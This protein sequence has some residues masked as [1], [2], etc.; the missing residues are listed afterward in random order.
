[1]SVPDLLIRAGV[2]KADHGWVYLPAV[3]LSFLVMGSTLFPLEKKGLLRPLFLG[4]IFL[5]FLV[6]LGFIFETRQTPTLWGLEILL[7]AFFCGFNI[8]EASQP[9]LASKIAPLRARASTLGIYNT[10]QSLGIFTGAALGGWVAKRIG[11]EG[12][13]AG[14]AV[15]LLLWMGASWHMTYYP[16]PSSN[17]S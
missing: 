5:V 14:A 6:Q 16:N 17:K 3:L 2:D 1:M 13:F 10:L 7:F 15:L 8:L 11:V 4:S 12:L 9:S